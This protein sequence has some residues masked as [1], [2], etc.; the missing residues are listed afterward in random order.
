MLDTLRPAELMAQAVYNGANSQEI[1]NLNLA[2]TGL[3]GVTSEVVKSPCM[4]IQ[5][6]TGLIRDYPIAGIGI[7]F[8]DGSMYQVSFIWL[9]LSL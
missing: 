5:Y 8:E 4:L 3:N 2:A 1:V 6:L 7:G 9:S